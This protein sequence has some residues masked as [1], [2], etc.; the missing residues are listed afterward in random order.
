MIKKAIIFF[1]GILFALS[2][3]GAFFIGQLWLEI[4]PKFQAINDEMIIDREAFLAESLIGTVLF[5]KTKATAARP[6]DFLARDALRYVK[7]ETMFNYH[8]KRWLLAKRLSWAYSEEELL[9]NWLSTV[10]LGEGEYGLETAALSLFGKSIDD[11]TEQESI[12]I[13]AL[14]IAPSRYRENQE[15]WE[16]RQGLL[17]EKWSKNSPR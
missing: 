12:A 3:A 14:V 1:S 16:L 6:E 15:A 4:K 8:L 11:M 10:Y 17:M 9:T 7:S 13:A 2:V 5:E